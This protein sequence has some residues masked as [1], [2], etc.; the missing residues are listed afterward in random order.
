MP[1]HLLI[2]NRQRVWGQ[3]RP[4]LGDLLIDCLIVMH[5]CYLSPIDFQ[6]LAM[7]NLAKETDIKGH[8]STLLCYRPSLSLIRFRP[9][10]RRRKTLSYPT[11]ASS[12]LQPHLDPRRALPAEPLV[13]LTARLTL[14]GRVDQPDVP[15]RKVRPDGPNLPLPIDPDIAPYKVRIP[16]DEPAGFFNR[17]I[18]VIVKTQAISTRRLDRLVS[19]QPRHR[20]AS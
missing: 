13:R 18:R 15:L 14:G 6:K 9:K 2:P 12:P 1:I 16:R 10:I 7:M 11:V 19:K 4:L 5:S 3:I 20:Y 17:Q 8:V